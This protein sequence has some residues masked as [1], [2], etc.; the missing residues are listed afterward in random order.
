MSVPDRRWPA[1]VA[2]AGAVAIAGFAIHAQNPPPALPAH[3]A[4]DGLFAAGSA[5]KHVEAIAHAPHP[6]GSE[7]SQRVRDTLIQRLEEIGLTAEIQLPKRRI[8]PCRK[9]C[10]LA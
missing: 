10:W 4:A 3:A 6:M 5:Q 9:M 1:W 8:R 7:E 2:A